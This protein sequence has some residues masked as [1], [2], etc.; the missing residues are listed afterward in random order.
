MLPINKHM[1]FYVKRGNT[2]CY[3][4]IYGTRPGLNNK[5]DEI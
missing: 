3:F 4:C 5:S 1:Y 2:N